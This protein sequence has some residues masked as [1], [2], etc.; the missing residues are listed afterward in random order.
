[1]E[2]PTFRSTSK[3]K[4]LEFIHISSIGSL[5]VFR[6]LNNAR[7]FCSR[8]S[9]AFGFCCVGT[10]V[11]RSSDSQSSS[12]FAHLSLISYHPKD[13]P[14]SDRNT[15]R[16]MENLKGRECVRACETEKE[17]KRERAYVWEGSDKS[18]E[19]NKRLRMLTVVLLLVGLVAKTLETH[20]S[21]AVS[22][23]VLNNTT[24]VHKIWSVPPKPASLTMWPQLSANKSTARA[25]CSCSQGRAQPRK[26][27]LCKSPAWCRWPIKG[28]R[29][30]VSHV[31]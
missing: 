11:G 22:P 27:P 6:L 23:R 13:V 19:I 18:N 12:R 20:P 7:R 30:H 21:S 31:P 15:G 26:V 1:M 3:S 16:Q 8:L 25:R 29:S 10:S 4:W 17:R 5:Y 24:A 9:G 28:T 14:R 2:Q